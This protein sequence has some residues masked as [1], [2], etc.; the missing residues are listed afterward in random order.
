MPFAHWLRD[1]CIKKNPLN[2]KATLQNFRNSHHFK[3][4]ARIYKKQDLIN[5]SIKLNYPNLK[6][7][8]IWLCVH[9]YK[10]SFRQGKQQHRTSYRIA[11]LMLYNKNLLLL[12][13][14]K[15]N[16]I[17]KKHFKTNQLLILRIFGNHS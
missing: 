12:K 10:I 3:K 11:K 16:E 8:A 4:A 1:G 5:T 13:F 9:I 7:K 2:E 14:I 6:T 17:M 15:W